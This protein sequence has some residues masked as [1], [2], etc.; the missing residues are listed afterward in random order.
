MICAFDNEAGCWVAAGNGPLRPIVVE[1]DCRA[2][3]VK[4]YG[5]A[6]HNQMADE[7]A[8]EQQMA[9]LADCTEG[10]PYGEDLG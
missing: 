7:Y 3:A 6:V 8:M 1:S 9:H 10:Q 5:E 4:A 2:G